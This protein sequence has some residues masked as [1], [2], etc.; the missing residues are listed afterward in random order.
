MIYTTWLFLI[1]IKETLIIKIYLSNTIK[2]NINAANYI[3][4][5]SKFYDNQNHSLW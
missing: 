1:I 4:G 2:L 3:I 5:Q